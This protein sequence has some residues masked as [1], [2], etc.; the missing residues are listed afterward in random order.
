MNRPLRLLLP[1]LVFGL[2]FIL[3]ASA[4]EDSFEA[5]DSL[6]LK[7]GRTVRGLIVKNT[8]N[9]VVLQQRLGETTYPKSTIVRIRDEA[10]TAAMFTEANRKGDLPAWRVIANDLRT[11]DSI[12]SLVEI[13]ATAIDIGEFRNIPYMSFRANHDLELNIYGDPEDPAGFEI[14]IYGSRSGNA[15]L[16]QDI[17]AFIAGFLATRAEIAALYALDMKGGLKTVGSLTLEITPKTAPDA[18]GAW[19]ISLYDRDALAKVRL[20][21]AAYKKL[22]LPMSEVVDKS[23]RVIANSW[24]PQETLMSKRLKRIGDDGSVI[25]RGFYRDKSGEFRLITENVP[26]RASASEN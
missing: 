9:S 24:T 13:P 11:H 4:A 7:D 5:P 14:G 6:L 25:L 22:T 2:G 19:W 20:T 16:R 1:A 21:D 15:R 8:W 17:R 3:V 12:R 10:N 18:A 26:A 23:G